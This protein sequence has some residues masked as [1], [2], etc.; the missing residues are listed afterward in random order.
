MLQTACIV[1]PLFEENH[2]QDPSQAE[3]KKNIY[4]YNFKILFIYLF[5]QQ[6]FTGS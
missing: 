5:D 1:L 2:E 4:I 3:L 6:C